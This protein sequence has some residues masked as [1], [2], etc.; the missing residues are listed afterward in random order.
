[1]ILRVDGTTAGGPVLDPETNQRAGGGTWRMMIDNDGDVK[2]R[3]R[4][5]I[6]PKKERVIEMIGIIER[7]SVDPGIPMASKAFGVPHLEA[8]AQEANTNDMVD[9]MH[10]SGEVSISKLS[11]WI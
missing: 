2:L 9:M 1:L 8:M 4:L 6:P 5:V 7:L 10:C 11:H 3:I